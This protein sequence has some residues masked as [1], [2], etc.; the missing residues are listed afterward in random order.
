MSQT[1][2]PVDQRLVDELMTSRKSKWTLTVVLHLGGGTM[3]FTALQREIGGISQKALS[4]T[5]RDLERDGFVSRT[6]YATIPPRVEYALTDLGGEALALFEMV[7]AFATRHWD[8]VLEARMAFDARNA[9][10]GLS[11][12]DGDFGR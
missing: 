4:A 6:S 5:L 2:E 3:R 9:R 7:R 10:S 11:L 1:R 12:L 8:R